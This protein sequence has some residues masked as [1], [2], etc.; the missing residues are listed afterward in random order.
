MVRVRFSRP[1]R[2]AAEPDED[3]AL[4]FDE[5]V[6]KYHKA[7]FSQLLWGLKLAATGFSPRRVKHAM[8]EAVHEALVPAAVELTELVFRAAHERLG[9]RG[10][11]ETLRV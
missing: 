10:G 9:S 7:I 8:S 5:L 1:K 6:T 2:R 4:S 11:E 3:A